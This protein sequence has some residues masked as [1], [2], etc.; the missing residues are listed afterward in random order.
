MF[1][2]DEPAILEG[3]DPFQSAPE[4]VKGVATGSTCPKLLFG[5]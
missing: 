4:E 1:S 2:I 5:P 3:V